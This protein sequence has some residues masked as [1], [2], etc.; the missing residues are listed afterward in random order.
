MLSFVTVL[1]L[2][3]VMIRIMLYF[4]NMQVNA[5]VIYGDGSW[6]KYY[7]TLLYS[8]L[9]AV[10]TMVFEPIAEALNKFEGHTT[11]V[12]FTRLYIPLICLA[13]SA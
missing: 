5:T 9:P 3:Y 6:Y 10:A 4:K 13:R 2:M 7:P 12:S 8:V 1:S 11:K